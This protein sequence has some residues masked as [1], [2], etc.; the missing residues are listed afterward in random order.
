MKKL[1]KTSLILVTSVFTFASLSTN[2]SMTLSPD[3]ATCG[4]EYQSS[5]RAPFTGAPTIT[6]YQATKS[7]GNKNKVFIKF[8]SGESHIV[9][10]GGIYN[11]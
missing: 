5:S 1:L 4:Y 6:I 9:Y 10:S 7:C 3:D 8:P 11:P 2:A